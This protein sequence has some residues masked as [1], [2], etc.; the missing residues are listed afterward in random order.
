MP[1]AGYPSK[2]K[3][4][5]SLILLAA[6]IAGVNAHFVTPVLLLTISS[7]FWGVS[8]FPSKI[9]SVRL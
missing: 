8:G 5:V 6:L 9:N 1:V 3:F 7:F 4:Y 2:F